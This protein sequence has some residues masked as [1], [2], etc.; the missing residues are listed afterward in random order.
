MT[1][2]VFRPYPPA[3]DSYEV[4]D[5]GRIKS[6]RRVVMRS[7]GAPQTLKERILQPY[8]DRKG[9]LYHNLIV[10]G[11][12]SRVYVHQAVILTFVGPRPEGA[13]C[14]HGDGDNQNNRAS[15]LRYGS[16]SDN[17]LDAVKHGTHQMT[18]KTTC[19]MGHPYSED[20]TSYRKTKNCRDC[21]ACKVMRIRL[22]SLYRAQI[23][24]RKNLMKN[25]DRL[26]A[27]IEATRNEAAA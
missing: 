7:N 20:N 27:Y 17:S 5:S 24:Q 10:D 26:S 21:I 4:S 8:P 19:P 22:R 12:K 15:N 13:L 1:A 25:A 18:R 9:Y 11:E 6:L 16:L 3:P 23:R 14:L 2:E